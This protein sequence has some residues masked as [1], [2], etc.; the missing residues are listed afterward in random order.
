LA[1]NE[2][3]KKLEYKGITFNMEELQLI[4]RL[5]LAT[6]LDRKNTGHKS[7]P[8]HLVER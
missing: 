5:A 6:D 1:L 3:S 4:E 2:T 7:V 8:S